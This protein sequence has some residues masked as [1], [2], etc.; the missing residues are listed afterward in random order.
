MPIRR[1]E[2]IRSHLS[3]F[4]CQRIFFCDGVA[5]YHLLCEFGPPGSPQ[6]SFEHRELWTWRLRDSQRRAQRD[7][8]GRENIGAHN[9]C[10]WEWIRSV[11]RSRDAGMGW[12]PMLSLTGDLTVY[13]FARD[14]RS[15][16]C[17]STP[18]SLLHRSSTILVQFHS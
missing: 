10:A 13:G 9:T 8:P 2:R 3:K 15:V 11:P 12:R 18:V 1:V 6:V 7:A 14:I 17:A 4:G 5:F 16:Q